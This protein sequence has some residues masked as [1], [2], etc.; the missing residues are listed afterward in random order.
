MFK[1]LISLVIIIS[2]VILSCVPTT[3]PITVTVTKPIYEAKV[4]TIIK[5]ITEN[6][7]I[8]CPK[9]LEVKTPELRWFNTLNEL[10][11][12]VFNDKT[13]DQKYVEGKFMCYEFA[14]M[15]IRNAAAQGF[16][17]FWYPCK[18]FDGKDHLR[19]ITVVLNE[20]DGNIEWYG[21]QPVPPE[22][23]HKII[24]NGRVYAVEPQG[25]MIIKY[26]VI[27]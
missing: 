17:M 3:A 11:D 27:D 6:I 18:D 23:Y 21:G 5:T 26:D 20:P 25:G 7:T 8:P 16:K 15:M 12:F 13:K 9:C 10:R 1:R 4:E 22:A 14:E 19:V 24:R 2:L